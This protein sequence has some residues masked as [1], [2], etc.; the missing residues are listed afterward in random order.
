[1]Q[2]LVDWAKVLPSSRYGLKSVRL[3]KLLGQE[4]LYAQP[5][6]D[7][8][9]HPSSDA[10]FSQ[11][12]KDGPKTERFSRSGRDR[13]GGEGRNADFPNVSVVSACNESPRST[14]TH[15]SSP[16]ADS[17]IGRDES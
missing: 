10:L 2:A 6:G 11:A 15:P 17:R 3:M 16:K 14:S 12:T 13:L 5:G 8:G 1:M 7:N 9:G 4:R